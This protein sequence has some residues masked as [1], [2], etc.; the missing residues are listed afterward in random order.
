MEIPPERIHVVPNGIDLQRFFKLEKFTM[1]IV[2]RLNLFNAAPLLLLPVR[3][4]PRKNLEMAMKVVARLRSNQPRVELIVTGPLGPH[5]PSN[6]RYF[7]ELSALRATLALEDCVHFLAELEENFIP[8]PVIADFYRLA[9][10]LILPSREEGFGIPILEA[11]ATGIP[12]FCSDIPPLRELAGDLVVYFPPDGDPGEVASE[13]ND[14]L[15]HDPAYQLRVRVR[16]NY[17]WE[18]VYAEKIE[19]LMGFQEETP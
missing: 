7:E 16:N 15:T 10:A 6:L 9:D 1:D 3:I 17:T 2:H 11:G 5:N 4:T 18:R 14:R 8:D 12:I 19:P 13:I